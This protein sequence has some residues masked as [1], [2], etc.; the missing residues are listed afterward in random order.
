MPRVFSR[1]LPLSWQLLQDWTPADSLC[2]ALKFASACLFN[3]STAYLATD[4]VSQPDLSDRSLE[5]DLNLAV[6]HQVETE[7]WQREG[8]K[9][10]GLKLA[11]PFAELLGD[12]KGFHIH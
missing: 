6:L 9:L 7:A 5:K 3:S 4:A 12:A 10:D 1:A 2:T 11:D 8:R